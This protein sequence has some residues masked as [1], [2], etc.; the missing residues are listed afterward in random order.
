MLVGGVG[1][2]QLVTGD[3]AAILDRLAAATHAPSVAAGPRRPLPP[4]PCSPSPTACRRSGGTRTIS[5]TVRG[6]DGRYV[7]AMLGFD[8]VDAHGRKLAL[9]GSPLTGAG[10]GAI[11]RM[12]YCLGSS[13]AAQATPGCRGAALT[14]R[15]SLAVPG[16]ATAVYVEAYP[17]APTAGN[18][19]EQTGYQGPDPG[20]TDQSAYGMSY[21]PHVSLRGSGA[22]GVALLLP[23]VCGSPGGSTGE[24][25]GH[26]SRDGRPWRAGGGTADAWA[27]G[28]GASGVLGMGIGQV[29]PGAGTY[30][31]RNLQP[32]SRY[33][34]IATVDGRKRQWLGQQPA[35]RACSS[36]RFDLDF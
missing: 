16:N 2:R 31:I 32:G 10:Y 24:I 22:T 12:N 17:K 36:T 25:W 9:D 29:D 5:G 19:L 18:W 21:R 26:L 11:E 4:N 15:W 30:R 3:G 33:T 28:P 1:A 14:D 34:I 27:T 6:A 8:I 7:D 20:V 23:R 13:G 35:V